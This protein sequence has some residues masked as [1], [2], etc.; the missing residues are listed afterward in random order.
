MQNK[1]KIV[2]FHSNDL[3]LESLEIQ[4]VD[5]YQR[6]P[7]NHYNLPQKNT[8]ELK[9]DKKDYIR[10][11]TER[12]IQILSPTNKTQQKEL[13]HLLKFDISKKLPKTYRKLKNDVKKKKSSKGTKREKNF[14]KIQSKSKITKISIKSKRGSLNKGSKNN[15]FRRKRSRFDNGS[16]IK[17]LVDSIEIKKKVSSHKKNQ[18][19]AFDLDINDNDQDKDI[20]ANIDLYKPK[21]SRSRKKRKTKNSTLQKKLI[22]KSSKKKVEYSLRATL[23]QTFAKNDSL[24]N[25]KLSSKIFEKN[26]SFES[27]KISSK[28][29][30]PKFQLEKIDKEFNNKPNFKELINSPQIK[31]KNFEKKTKTSKKNIDL[32]NSSNLKRRDNEHKSNFMKDE[33]K[34]RNNQEILYFEHKRDNI[35]V[36]NR[37]KLNHILIKDNYNNKQR[38]LKNKNLLQKSCTQFFNSLSKTKSRRFSRDRAI[39]SEENRFIFYEKPD[40]FKKNKNIEKSEIENLSNISSIDDKKIIENHED[41]NQDEDLQDNKNINL[42]LSNSENVNIIFKL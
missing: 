20:G 27:L 25:L 8:N 26:D 24:E 41:I 10:N 6:Y 7:V 11:D 1:T 17:R 16:Q 3:I 29:S 30:S 19:M 5:E 28:I 31:N 13:S 36:I 38:S 15:Y 37:K 39:N 40:I 14:K 18:S 2:G 42:I 9:N 32:R 23:Q 35:N 12:K 34:E 4:N 33:E 21:T 22:K